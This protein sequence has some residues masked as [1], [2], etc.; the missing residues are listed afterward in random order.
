MDYFR[1]RRTELDIHAA[2]KAALRT[3]GD[4]A[5]RP[6]HV[7]AH[8][9]LTTG[10]AFSWPHWGSGN[11]YHEDANGN[12]VYDWTTLDQVFDAY[13]E[14]GMRPLVELGFTPARWSRP[15]QTFRLPEAR[16][17]TNHMKLR[18]GACLRMTIRSG[19]SSSSMWSG[20]ASKDMARRKSR[21]GTGNSGTNQTSSTGA[22][23]PNS[24]TPCMT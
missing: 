10:R 6:Y 18:F 12:P 9:L 7:R 22:G 19:V 17:S 16:R 13:I 3:F 5:E 15:K 23:R 1:I 21:P 11:V 4:F 14:A 2:R 8:N 20:T 24:S